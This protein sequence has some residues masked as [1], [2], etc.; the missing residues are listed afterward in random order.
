MATNPPQ[1]PEPMQAQI[2][3]H[4][5]T[6]EKTLSELGTSKAGLSESEAASR[7][8]KYGPNALPEKKGKSALSMLFDQFKD[9]LIILL[10]VAAII[11]AFLGE[12]LDAAAIIVVVL[13]N[14]VLGFV[15]EYRAEKALES[16]KKLVAF[17][18]VVFRDGKQR[19]I[20][21][22]ALVPGDVILLEA[23]DK[24]PADC[25]LIET[26]SLEIDEASLTG[27]S[28]PVGKDASLIGGVKASLQ[29]RANMA[30][31]STA[32]TRGKCF[33]V[34]AFTSVH[35][36]IGRVAELVQSVEEEP[37]PL[38][39]KLEGLGKQLGVI[40][41]AITAFIFVLGVIRGNPWLDMFLLSV[42]LAVAAIPEGL[43]TVVTVT[44]AV[45]VQRMVKRNAIIRKLPAVEGLG[46]ATVICSDKTG[47]LT[48]NEMTV[49]NFFADGRDYSVSGNGYSLRGEFSVQGRQINYAKE[50]GL[51]KLLETAVLC[52][53]AALQHEEEEPVAR[54]IGDPTEACL[55]VAAY[56]AGVQYGKQKSR[57]KFIDEIVFDSER[58]MMSV[59][60]ELDGGTSS[61]CKGAPESVLKE[62]GY[63]Y[64]NGRVDK[65]S[66]KDRREI[67]ARNKQYAS[68]ALRVLAF[69][70]KELPKKPKYCQQDAETGMVF[71]GLAGMI[72]PPRTEAKEAVK[73]CKTAGIK[74]IMITGDNIDTAKAIARELGIG[75]DSALSGPELE[76]LSDA[77]LQQRAKSVTVY[78][79]VS[80]EHKLRIVTAL[81][82]NGEIV[83]MTGDGVNDAPSI[84][85]ADVGISMGITG[86]EVAKESSKMVIS[87][88][89]FASI[90]AAVEEGRVIYDNILK[91]VKYLVSCN[92]GEILV[93][94]FAILIGFPAPLLPLQ[95]LWTNLITDTFPALALAMDPKDPNVM[96]RKPRNAQEGV[97]N[98]GNFTKLFLIGL[99]MAISTFGAFY[100]MLSN[101]RPIEAARAMAFSILVITQKFIAWSFRN[102]EQSLV[103]VGLWSNK[104]LTITIIVGVLLQIAIVQT[105]YLEEVFGTM[106]LSLEEWVAVFALSMAPFISMEVFKHVKK[107]PA[108]Q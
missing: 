60:Y 8:E 89:N 42:S 13:I 62:C 101:G 18:A 55:L 91:A 81:Q 16:L 84:K 61:F 31:M 41:V 106:A 24:V 33:A 44:L 53:N 4:S 64:R 15:Q 12:T 83:A 90:V 32:V 56:K 5:F 97:L 1:P 105:T 73:L 27:E 25:R 66:D 30:F 35:T 108:P 9:F 70:F 50:S 39:Q 51:A 23:G 40:A 22:S 82:K 10:I 67:L 36:Q 46:A 104:W 85:K 65:I 93:I 99:V 63:I 34:V 98:R 94:F 76:A 74:V 43:P 52:N 79:R 68:A 47:T 6:A 57:R 17:T 3:F 2:P 103:K 28:L 87:D 92:I 38:Q 14:S 58:K 49:R 54:I 29:D 59:V 69:A 78:A 77:E 48:R 7:L 71:V 75:G 96:N 80:P 19:K 26:H 21:V 11:S 45:G 88:D 107:K 72:D 100:M 20:D 102:E 86:T 95:I 37:T